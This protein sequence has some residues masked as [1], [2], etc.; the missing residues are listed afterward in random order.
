ADK[1]LV[2]Q[3]VDTVVPIDIVDGGNCY[4]GCTREVHAAA[5]VSGSSTT[6][7]CTLLTTTPFTSNDPGDGTLEVTVYCKDG[8]G[9][10]LAQG[11]DVCQF[12]VCVDFAW[13]SVENALEVGLGQILYDV[14]ITRSTQPRGAHS[15]HIQ[16][17]DE[18]GD[19]WAGGS[20]GRYNSWTLSRVLAD[21]SD[22]ISE[23]TLPE[24]HASQ[25]IK[26]CLEDGSYVF[27]TTANAEWSYDMGWTVCNHIGKAGESVSFTVSNGVCEVTDATPLIVVAEAVDASE[28]Y[29]TLPAELT[30]T[31]LSDGLNL[32]G[33]G[34]YHDGRCGETDLTGC[35]ARTIDNCRFC[36][37]DR[38]A[39]IATF[40][41]ERMPDWED[42]P[43]CVAD[44]V[45]AVCATAGGGSGG[46]M[47]TFINIAIGVSCAVAISVCIACSCGT[48]MVRSVR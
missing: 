42:C 27:S 38:E 18:Y 25:T 39:W 11:R 7:G 34:L 15:V 48:Q 47:E 17:V 45:G 8:T 32:E 21:G 3:L 46:N 31:S 22:I 35:N 23:G 43:C 5:H 33:V 16:L 9:A 20:N 30:C 1:V 4:G 36:F 19:G 41:G 26:E 14:V 10:L 24:D 6:P 28:S 2:A 37:Y 44:N 13:R 40:P 29:C 12:E